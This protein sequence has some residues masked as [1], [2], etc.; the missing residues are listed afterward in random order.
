MI[1]G[2][3]IMLLPHLYLNGRCE[4]A[5]SQYVKAFSAEVK[6]LIPFPENE[7]QKG[8][9]HSEIYIHGQRIMLNDISGNID[10]T[11]RGTLE[12]VVIYNNV[13]DL[14]I[15]YEIMKEGSRTLSPMQ[16]TFYTPCQVEFWD[17]FGILW[18]FMVG[19]A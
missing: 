3:I 6:V 8:V 18:G 9:M 12:L 11:Q 7:P 10:C 4:E 19:K 1:G 14:K 15:S 5:I 17:K 13:E 2:Q 16:A